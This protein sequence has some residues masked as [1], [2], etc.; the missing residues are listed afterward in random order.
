EQS[1]ALRALSETLPMSRFQQLIA[2]K[3]FEEAEAFAKQFELDEQMVAK[4]R[5][6]CVLSEMATTAVGTKEELGAMLREMWATLGKINVGIDW[7]SY[8]LEYTDG[9]LQDELF[10]IDLCLK[11]VMPTSETARQMLEHARTL[12]LHLERGEASPA[13]HSA[14]H[15]VH[16]SVRR[17]GTYQLIKAGSS[18][19]GVELFDG[20]DWQRF[21]TVDM[22]MEMRDYLRMGDLRDAIVIWRRHYLD[23]NLLS[24]LQD[25]FSDLRDDAS[26]SEYIPWLES[27]VLP[28]IA[29]AHDRSR[30]AKWIEGRA[31]ITERNQGRPHDALRVIKMLDAAF[32]PS[33]S[34]ENG[35][36][37]LQLV[38]P[39]TPARYV[40]NSCL[41]AAGAGVG[42]EVGESAGGSLRAQLE[43]LV[44]LWDKHDF[45]VGWADYV[46]T[47]PSGI[48]LELLDR[49]AAVELLQGAVERHFLPYVERNGLDGDELLVEYCV[50]LM[51]GGG[52]ASTA[53]ETV[54]EGRGLGVLECVRGLDCRVDVCL[55][56]MKRVSVP[57]SEG[58][59][60]VLEESLGWRGGAPGGGRA[61][62]GGCLPPRWGSR[63]GR[64]GEELR[65][66]WQLLVLKRMLLGYGVEGFNISDKSLAKGLLRKILSRTDLLHAM[67]DALLVVN[68]YHHLSKIET[69]RIRM[70]NLCEVGLV[71]RAVNL[72]RFGR[73]DGV[74]GMEGVEKDGVVESS[75]AGNE[76][77]LDGMDALEAGM[78]VLYYLSEV[79]DEAVGGG[80]DGAEPDRETFAW[81]ISAAVPL[82]NLLE[83]MAAELLAK[84][85]SDR[86]RSSGARHSGSISSSGRKSN[87]YPLA[88]ATN[89][90]VGG[91]GNVPF[92]VRNVKALFEEFGIL[93]GLKGYADVRERRRVLDGFA[94]RVFR[95]G[96]VGGE[97]G[98]GGGKGKG[99]GKGVGDGA[100]EIVLGFE[101]SE[102]RG[103]LAEQA[104]KCGDFRTALVICKEMYDKFP[105]ASTAKVLKRIA[106]FLTAYASENKQVYRDVKEAK[107][108]FRLT[109]RIL[110]LSEQALAVCGADIIQG[111]LD[112]F[113]NYELQHSVFS[114]CDAGDYATL[115]LKERPVRRGKAAASSRHDLGLSASSAS[116]SS[117]SIPSSRTSRFELMDEDEDENDVFPKSTAPL[118]TDLEVA[119]IQ[120]AYASHLFDDH[121]QRSGLVLSTERAMEMVAEFVLDTALSAAGAEKE[122]SGLVVHKSSRK[123]KGVERT[124]PEKSGGLL[125]QFLLGNGNLMEALRVLHRAEEARLRFGK[126][127]WGEGEAGESVLRH[128]VILQKL[129]QNVLSSKHIDQR[130]GLG[131][132]MALPQ[133][134]AFE[135][136]KNG[137]GTTNNDYSRLVRIA[138]IGIV[139]GMAWQQMGLKADSQRLAANGRWWHQFRLLDIPFDHAEFQKPTGDEY[140]RNLV[141]LLLKRTGLDLLTA[142]EFGQSYNIED[143][144]IILE[145]IRQLL[146]PSPENRDTIGLSYQ[147]RVA[148]VVDDVVNRAKVLS[149]I[150]EQCLPK[151]SSYDY[152]RIKFILTQMMRLQPEDEVTK[153]GS[154]ALD[155]LSDYTRAVPPMFTELLEAKRGVSSIA[156][157]SDNEN[158]DELKKIFPKSL[159][160]LPFHRL[161]QD[162]WAVLRPELSSDSITRLLA[163]SVP[164]K[165]PPD[166]FYTV[167]IENMMRNGDYDDEA[168]NATSSGGSSPTS[169]SPTLRARFADIKPFI[170]KYREEGVAIRM[171]VR[172][173]GQFPCGPER[174]SAYKAALQ[175]AERMAQRAPEGGNQATAGEVPPAHVVARVK[176][177]LQNT[178]T[179]DQLRSFGLLDVLPYVKNQADQQDSLALIERLY[180]VKSEQALDHKDSFDLHGL[181]NDICKRY[182]LPDGDVIRAHL[183]KTWLGQEV[184][185]SDEQ[186]GTYLPSTRVQLSNMVNSRDE[187]AI[188]KRLLY[189]LRYGPMQRS[190]KLL[191][192]YA[193]QPTAKVLTLNRVRALSVL[194][195]LASPSDL[196]S[197]GTKYVDVKKYMQML[198]YLADFEELRI[199]QSLREFGDC[200]KEALARSLWLYHRDKPK[201]VQLICNICLDYNIHDLTLWESALHSLL[202]TGL[203]RY[204]LGLLE[205]L[206]AI[207]ELAQMEYLPKLW[208]DVLLG[209]LKGFVAGKDSDT[210]TYTRV[211]SL[212]Q[213]CPFLSGIDVD[214]FVAQFRLIAK[215]GAGVDLM[216]ERLRGLASLPLLP[217]TKTAIEDII[218][219]IS[220]E[221]MLKI[222]DCIEGT[223][224]EGVES[225]T[226]GRADVDLLV[227]KGPII[228][229]LY[230]RIDSK[231]LY[232]IVVGTK[233][234]ESFIQYLVDADRVEHLVVATLKA[235]RVE[236]GLDLM[237]FYYGRWPEKLEDA[238][239]DE[240]DAEM[241]ER[242]RMLA[243]S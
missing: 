56:V 77:A 93:R 79:M 96:G 202:E 98:G 14:I 126:G 199:I 232:E 196:E 237:R 177:M 19:S 28:F 4:A 53:G 156:I 105:D 85:E 131:C 97:G 11:A 157:V 46:R 125:A 40:E 227:S 184:Q 3:R 118:P 95:Y 242:E 158:L 78:E 26:P 68:A 33:Q 164:L 197:V 173:G 146:L 107:M 62:G 80:D 163:L 23:E 145:Y 64:G 160:R 21:R 100:M 211:I 111:C 123:D 221:E 239:E 24:Q 32:G 240:G 37:E 109:S 44:C 1:L 192:E 70:I 48:A 229:A 99:K 127:Y 119:N 84:E 54:W 151:V 49:V 186:R 225:Q 130:M 193:Y 179:E 187:I 205:H 101:R 228:Q 106:H 222:L 188:Q 206:S 238:R 60:K 45:K 230:D 166:E 20:K 168:E 65:E 165:L 150:K 90:V 15:G 170:M 115:S 22:V 88:A 182:S 13:S 161:V 152:E 113:K 137:L 219:G 226:A 108:H 235:G 135:A 200:D 69:Y 209:C 31:R 57:W 67:D 169:S 122:Y 76:A 73:E 208:N 213:K 124:R 155:I 35:G 27:E 180:L 2:H 116:G 94:G 9:F 132:M 91:V 185:V 215:G 5:L 142:L 133:D 153:R 241:G 58:V 71:E 234:V 214:A 223:K 112:D 89:I 41:V 217:Q 148:G 220:A 154:V 114:Q 81:A 72:L 55:E 102:L 138:P 207:P 6:N 47:T 191:T 172:V 12:V 195:Q 181:V 134:L 38:T 189:L 104:A 218:G 120:D 203:H 87:V 243:V 36:G 147:T 140:R 141:P 236:S 17:L 129:I 121:F 10:C 59:G 92:V 83:T 144:F 176:A 210:R 66:Q 110:Q 159:Q 204:L 86:S 216:I 39:A 212:L 52:G 42:E 82:T 233:H 30:L 75:G 178:E 174:I 149:L 167:V 231:R 29:D 51:D 171:A 16:S 198:L 136:Y 224:V 194:F 43:D 25:I 61:G 201:V 117:S 18:I 139:S 74:V 183:A 143:D 190:V 50:E 103:I 8:H 7:R 175:I 63:R 162:P 128:R 34:D